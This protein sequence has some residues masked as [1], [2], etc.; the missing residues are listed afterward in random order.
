M[1]YSITH[2][3]FEIAYIFKN[4][5]LIKVFQRENFEKERSEKFVNDLKEKS[6]KIASVYIRSTPIMEV[7]TGIVIAILMIQFLLYNKN[8]QHI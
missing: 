8:L 7:L 6:I 1:I 3:I 4:H 2:N 5:K